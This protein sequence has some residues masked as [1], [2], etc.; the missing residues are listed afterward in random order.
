VKPGDV[1]PPLRT[2]DSILLF[3]LSDAQGRQ[4]KKIPIPE[5]TRKELEKR[6]KDAYQQREARSSQKQDP[7][8]ADDIE[9]RDK[10]GKGKDSAKGGSQNRKTSGI[11]SAA[12]EKEYDLVRNKVIAILRND[13]IQSRMK[14]WVEDLRK[15]SIIDVKL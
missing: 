14:E 3:H 9:P 13:K 12:D 2:K 15:N 6:W 8:S 11:L 10:T 7:E 4:I 1:T 5:K